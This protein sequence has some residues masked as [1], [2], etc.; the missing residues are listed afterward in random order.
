MKNLM[1]LSMKEG[2]TVFGLLNEF[3]SLFSQLTSQGFDFDEELKSIFL[4]CSLPNSWDIFCT[5]ISNLAPNGK[6]VFNDVTNALLTKEIRHKSLDIASHGDAYMVGSSHEKQRGRHKYSNNK[7]REQ[8]LRNQK[9]KPDKGKSSVKIEEINVVESPMPFIAVE[10]VPTPMMHV[11]PAVIRAEVKVDPSD[12]LIFTADL[13][14]DSLV[15]HDE[16]YAQNWI[17][18]S[19]TSFHVTLHRD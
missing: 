18:D 17:L 9:D 11:M 7:S 2:N 3:N 6:L 14:P 4:L 15:A 13:T 1:K 12:V 16:G 19:G 10:D 5:A 8:N